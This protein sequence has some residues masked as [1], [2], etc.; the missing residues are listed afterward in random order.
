M[1]VVKTGW[2][3]CERYWR[4]AVAGAA[5]RTV[6]PTGRSRVRTRQR[7]HSA[8]DVGMGGGR[9]PARHRRAHARGRRHGANGPGRDRDGCVC[10]QVRGGA[11]R[12]RRRRHRPRADARDRGVVRRAHRAHARGPA[13]SWPRAADRA[14]LP[15][16]QGRRHGDRDG[17][18]ALAGAG[19]PLH[20]PADS[21]LRRTRAARAVWRRD[22]GRRGAG[23]VGQC[24]VG[25]RGLDHRGAVLRR[26][27]RP[28]RPGVADPRRLRVQPRGSG[29]AGRHRGDAPSARA[30]G[31]RSPPVAVL[32]AAHEGL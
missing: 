15:R 9:E 30:A 29:R 26:Q 24:A 19:D 16:P 6:R 13:D 10:G 11:C 8:G 5:G 27:A 12:L 4:A 23:G 1:F 22:S 32:A 25:D 28:H 18:G 31:C 21:A 7:R 20:P 2:G 17:G 3:Q 14:A